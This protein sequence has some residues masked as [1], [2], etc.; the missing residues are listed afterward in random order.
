MRNSR[1]NTIESTGID[2]LCFK[3]YGQQICPREVILLDASFITDWGLKTLQI[4]TFNGSEK[5]VV[6]RGNCTTQLVKTGIKDL[7]VFL[8]SCPFMTQ[9]IKNSYSPVSLYLLTRNTDLLLFNNEF[10]FLHICSHGVVVNTISFE[11]P[12]KHFQRVNAFYTVCDTSHTSSI[13]KVYISNTNHKTL[14]NKAQKEMTSIEL[15]TKNQ[16]QTELENAHKDTETG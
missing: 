5:S 6:A 2:F 16:A 4:S 9:F 3:S 8:N 14:E 12:P 13:S 1:T 11:L 15:V 10:G 7:C